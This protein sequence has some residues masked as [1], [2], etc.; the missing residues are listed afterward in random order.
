MK[1]VIIDDEKGAREVLSIL[2]QKHCP[3]VKVIGEAESSAQGLELLQFTRPDL[4]FIDIQMPEESGIAMLR[5]MGKFDFDVIFVTSYHEYA[6]EALRLHALD[7][8]LK[9]VNV[10]DLRSAVERARQR[11]MN[12]LAYHTAIINIINTFEKEPGQM[13]IPAHQNGAVH[14]VKLNDIEYV[15]AQS[16][17]IDLITDKN[18]FT[19]SKTLAEFEEMVKENASFIRIDKS[20]LLNVSRIA[21]YYKSQPC[22]IQMKSGKEFEV[23][24]RKRVAVL[25]LLKSFNIIT[26]E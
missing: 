2:L 23:S 1:A 14:L 17:Y 26:R 5:K 10:E 15:L 24:R 13:H 18:R 16:N 11:R 8:L 7:Y 9:P 22:I 19:V 21:L 4:L 12:G 25:A 3:D 20:C 6:I